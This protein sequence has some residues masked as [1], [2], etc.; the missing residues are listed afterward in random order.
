[1]KKCNTAEIHAVTPMYLGEVNQHRDVPM[2]KGCHVA[3]G[4]SCCLIKNSNFDIRSLTRFSKP[5]SNLVLEGSEQAGTLQ[6]FC[7]LSNQK[8]LDFSS[9]QFKS[10]IS[11]SD[12]SPFNP[13]TTLKV[14]KLQTPNKKYTDSTKMRI[15]EMIAPCGV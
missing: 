10:L 8:K 12:Q 11:S 2:H 14:S 4:S 3:H 15:L 9:S 5:E 1:M 13:E 7:F 6:L